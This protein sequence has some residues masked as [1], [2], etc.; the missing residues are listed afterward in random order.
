MTPQTNDLHGFF[1]TLDQHQAV[2]F[3]NRKTCIEH[4]QSGDVQLQEKASVLFHFIDDAYSVLPILIEKAQAVN[5]ERGP[6]D[7]HASNFVGYA[8]KQ[9]ARLV[10]KQGYSEADT[11]H[12]RIKDWI[13]ELNYCSEL[14]VAAH[15]VTAL[16]D[17][18]TPPESMRERL[19]ELAQ[20]QIRPDNPLEYPGGT[21]RCLAFREL[22]SRDRETALTLVDT[23]ARHEFVSFINQHLEL[24]RVKYP[25]NVKVPTALKAE[26]A[27]LPNA[28]A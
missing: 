9:S 24:Y 6:I 27:W 18:W 25:N 16:G 23:P 5:V 3:M 19:I 14:N 1:I 7:I 12:R 26:I 2:R 22:S 8:V 28:N 17:L 15:S 10:R 13:L 4:L 11:F 20:N 21:V